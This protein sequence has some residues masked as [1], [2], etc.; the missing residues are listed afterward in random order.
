MAKVRVDSWVGQVLAE[1]S[2][3]RL[4]PVSD[5]A[6]AGGMGADPLL[7]AVF[8]PDRWHRKFEANTPLGCRDLG[9]QKSGLTAGRY[10]CLVE[11]RVANFGLSLT[12]PLQEVWAR[13]C[14]FWEYLVQTDGTE[15]L[16][17][18][19]LLA[20]ETWVAKSRGRQLGGTSACWRL[21]W[22]TS[23]CH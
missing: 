1:G 10:K 3:G 14:C 21:E 6:P 22:P 18:T 13:T 16:R 7:L 20:V 5:G 17:P 9:G 23:S 19:L 8:S 12:V 4:R 11:A 15:S 2:R